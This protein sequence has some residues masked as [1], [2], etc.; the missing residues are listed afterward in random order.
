M[1][2]TRGP[3]FSRKK[4]IFWTWYTST[5]PFEMYWLDLIGST[6]SRRIPGANEGVLPNSL[7]KH[8]YNVILMVT[9][10]WVL[11]PMYWKLESTHFAKVLVGHQGCCC[12]ASHCHRTGMCDRL[13]FDTEK[14]LG[15]REISETINTILSVG[16]YHRIYCKDI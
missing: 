15:H 11:H 5:L 10:I 2:K 7:L 6:F 12:A 13:F 16:R 14:R 3:M 1:L 8:R 9:V 4:N